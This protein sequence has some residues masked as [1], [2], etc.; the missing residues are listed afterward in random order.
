[1]TPSP[2]GWIADEIRP[3]RESRATVRVPP[4]MEPTPV[5]PPADP[6][7]L[8]LAQ[9]SDAIRV[10]W[11]TVP[12][13]GSFR[14]YDENHFYQE[15]F[16]HYPSVKSPAVAAVAFGRIAREGDGVVR[17]YHVTPRDDLRGAEKVRW[18][19]ARKRWGA[20]P[21]RWRIEN[22]PAGAITLHQRL[23]LRE[24]RDLARP[25]LDAELVKT[26][27][28]TIARPQAPA[29]PLTD[30]AIKL[31]LARV[32]GRKAGEQVHVES[33]RDLVEALPG[34]SWE[35]AVLAEPVTET[36]ARKFG[37]RV[38]ATAPDLSVHGVRPLILWRGGDQDVT[39]EDLARVRAFVE[40]REGVED[41]A[42]VVGALGTLLASGVAS[43]VDVPGKRPLLYGWGRTVIVLP[44]V[45]RI[46]A[47]WRVRSPSGATYALYRDELQPDAR[48]APRRGPPPGA[49]VFS[50]GFWTWAYKQGLAEAAE[51]VVASVNQR[52]RE[53]ALRSI[54]KDRTHTGECQ[55][56]GNIYKLQ[57]ANPPLM[58]DHGF[59]FPESMGV[60][61][62][63]LGSLGPRNGGCPGV[64]FQPYELGC[65]RLV[66]YRPLLME[67]V[68]NLEASLARLKSDKQSG[69]DIVVPTS[70]TRQLQKG[71]R[72]ANTTVRHADDPIRWGE[73]YQRTMTEV[74]MTLGSARDYLAW[75]VNRIETWVRRPLYDEVVAA[76]RQGAP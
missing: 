58:V 56:C 19:N 55:M 65:D 13:P 71:E 3:A 22:G 4:P 21:T 50:K 32:S 45:W 27:P 38:R 62:M 18:T 66:W 28:V 9:L 36:L 17:T 63:G 74:N 35:E 73:F 49:L 53:H 43:L 24:T 69:A 25:Y 42:P 15:L 61:G 68:R 39:D 72:D 23:T 37:D 6:F 46:G 11:E 48:P 30:G 70:W 51:A 75:V 47:A 8:L 12:E 2:W 52:A 26:M 10:R 31:Y 5:P 60:R 20:E 54:P 64:N 33:T 40:V 14:Y 41:D 76:K 44:R 34:W 7:D 67:R 1:M 16:E 57:P 29:K 59:S